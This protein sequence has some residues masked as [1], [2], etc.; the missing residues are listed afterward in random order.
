MYNIYVFLVV[1]YISFCDILPH[2]RKVLCMYIYMYQLYL[3]RKKC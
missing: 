3:S 2:L 1:E